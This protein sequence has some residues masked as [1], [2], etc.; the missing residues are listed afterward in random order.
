[1][2][3]IDEIKREIQ[4]NKSQIEFHKQMLN[5]CIYDKKILEELLIGKITEI[6]VIWAIPEGRKHHAH[7]A[8]FFSTEEKA[9]NALPLNSTTRDDIKWTY[10]VE[11]ITGDLSKYNLFDIDDVPD[12]FPYTER[13]NKN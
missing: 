6:Y 4:F 11:R 2:N 1:M 5:K 10:E 7:V 3:T 8:C 12:L 13:K 9:K